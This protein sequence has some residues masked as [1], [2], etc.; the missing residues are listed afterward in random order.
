MKSIFTNVL[1]A[2]INPDKNFKDDLI[3]LNAIKIAAKMRDVSIEKKKT[4]YKDLIQN[5]FIRIIM[6][7]INEKNR[8]QC[9]K[10]LLIE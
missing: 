1:D 8:Q 7:D 6:E 9:I 10:E 2:V 3:Q 4:D 5:A